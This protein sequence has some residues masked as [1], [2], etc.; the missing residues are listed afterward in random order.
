MLTP[1]EDGAA[2]V[3]LIDF[4][5]ARVEDAQLA[6]VTTVS[7]GIGTIRYMA[8]EQLAGVLEQTSAVDIYSFAI[9]VYEMLTGELPFN[10]QSIVEMFQLQ[11]EG[12]KVS[13]RE[14]REDLPEEAET[15]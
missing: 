7:R 1:Q 6:P 5:I 8:P 11:K 12:V 15:I 13:P 10:P 9:V 4:G 2:R 3:R 14:L